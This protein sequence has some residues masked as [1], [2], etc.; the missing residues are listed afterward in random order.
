MPFFVLSILFTASLLTPV[1]EPFAPRAAAA[2]AAAAPASLAPAAVVMPPLAPQKRKAYKV[3]GGVTFNNAIGN[4]TQRRAI[5][6]K[7]TRTIRNAPKGSEVR[8]FSWKIWTYA[9]VTALINAHKRGV[10]VR[11]IMF[12]GN[13]IVENNPHFWRLKRG[14]QAG[15]KKRPKAKR[16]GAR[17]CAGSCRGTSGTSHSKFFT[18]SKAGQSKHVY[19]HTSSNWG[20]AAATRQWNDMYTLVGNKAVYDT[21]VRVFDEAWKDKPVKRPWVEESIDNGKVVFAWG[22]STPK[23]IKND[24]VVNTLAKVKCVGA[25]GGAG[26]A[27]GRTVIRV[28]PD[29][30][31]GGPGMKV[32]KHLK[33]LWDAG[34]DVKVA[35]TVIGIDVRQ[36]LAGAG[37]RGPVPMR[38]LV[39]DFDGDG[40]FDRYFHMKTYTINGRIG[41]NT[42]AYFMVQGSANTS[43]LALHSDETYGYFFDRASITKRYQNHI[44]YWFTHFP[45]VKT[46]SPSVARRVASGEIDPY[47]KINADY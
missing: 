38:H 20:D 29:V 6:N 8:I 24:R 1:A 11:A 13:T 41:K 39:Q 14:L 47:A 2:P 35:Y 19:M 18:F 33:R 12:E 31:R 9:G 5:L 3:K 16:S 22:P 34:C 4:T 23:A 44:D 46:V 27:N 7:V 30:M 15:N 43:G 10:T 42:E 25:T 17:L 26:N 32:A 45:V 21:A 36:H 37:G 28:A 40:I